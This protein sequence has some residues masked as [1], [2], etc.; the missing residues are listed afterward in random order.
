MSILPSCKS[1]H[2]SENTALQPSDE[3]VGYRCG[4]RLFCS[5]KFSV[6]GGDLGDE[7]RVTQHLTHNTKAGYLGLQLRY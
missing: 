5:T 1:Y 6:E 2:A 3:I 7:W 4:G